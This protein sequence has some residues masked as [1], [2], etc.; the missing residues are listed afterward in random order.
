MKIGIVVYSA[1]GN[2]LSVA[3]RIKK[4]LEAK[5][6]KAD[7]LRV[8]ASGSSSQTI[9]LISTPDLTGY[10]QL[11][12]GAPINGF[13]LCRA[14]Q[15]YLKSQG[16]MQG[17]TI[18]CFVTQQLKHSFLGGN[19][20]IRLMCELCETNGGTIQNTAIVHWSSPRRESEIE[21]AVTMM[22]GI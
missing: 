15:M 5:G 1:T 21:T 11:I 14:M 2:T 6:K 7:L 20:G 3:E 17:R 4:A 13:M 16:N 18:N 8:T 22:S 9:S 19:Q 10:D 12:I